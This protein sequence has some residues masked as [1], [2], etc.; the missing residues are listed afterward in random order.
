MDDKIT[1]VKTFK[2]GPFAFSLNYDKEKIN[3]LAWKAKGIYSA[4]RPIPILP[5]LLT[6]LEEELIRRS[7]FGT[8]AI[9]GN[10]LSE[11]Q[12][13]E[14]L[15]VN[16][17]MKDLKQPERQISNLKDAYNLI[18][19]LS[20]DQSKRF[21]LDEDVIKKIH[22]TIT[23][24][25]QEKN[26]DPGKYRNVEVKVGD[27]EHGGVYTPPKILDDITLLM[28][29]FIT[30]IN[31]D[32][33][34]KE[35]PAVRA[36]LAHYYF[37]LI[38]P[39]GNGNGRTARAI[40]ALLLKND[41]RIKFFVCVMLSNYYYRNIDGYFTAFSLSERNETYD[42]TPFLEFFLGG[43]IA[44]FEEVRFKII[45]WIRGQTLKNY[46]KTLLSSK[47][48]SQRQYDLLTV[49]IDTGESFELKELFEKDRFLVIYRD[50]SERT[51]RRD[52][53]ELSDKKLIEPNK[54]NK[55]QL[56]ENILDQFNE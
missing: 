22:S 30:W 5:Q 53:E 33:V 38:H 32:R 7:I 48:I 52:I 44:S 14:V 1:K 29:E 34:L 45:T 54:D 31:S 12:V 40:E 8:A 11:Q 20:I 43:L 10:P 15:A 23:N 26:N 25:A 4:I 6:Q 28:K 35:D 47:E 46:H 41:A 9:E 55:Y 17:A 37:A 36:A 13:G 27:K 21:M 50:V 51:A 56:G 18:R 16:G 24:G 49:L 42:V 39:F 3:S 19:K 2:S